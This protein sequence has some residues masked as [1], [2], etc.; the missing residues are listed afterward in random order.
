MPAVFLSL[1]KLYDRV[2]KPAEA[3]AAFRRFLEVAPADHE[4]RGFA[5]GEVARLTPTTN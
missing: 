2:G 1:G 4:Q 3:L 5:E